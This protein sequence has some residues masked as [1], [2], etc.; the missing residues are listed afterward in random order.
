MDKRRV[1]LMAMV[2]F[3][4]ANA[5]ILAQEAAEAVAAAP[6]AGVA[7]VIASIGLV[8]VNI[9][10]PVLMVLASWAAYKLAKKFG[11]ELGSVE[12][13]IVE[14][15]VRQAINATEK[16]AQKQADQPT[17]REKLVKA[18]AT[19]NAFLKESGLKQKGA[20]Y[21]EGLVESALEEKE[22]EMVVGEPDDL[23]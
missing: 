21:L 15:Y 8:L 5:T 10:T 13:K 19:A 2:A 16:W 12:K 7:P 22:T 4:V 11:I 14:G 20:E 9:L 6:D 18:I 23:E 3:V 1:G 17:S